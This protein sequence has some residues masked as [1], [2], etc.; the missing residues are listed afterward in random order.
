[1]TNNLLIILFSLVFIPKAFGASTHFRLS[2]EK[3]CYVKQ[4]KDKQFS[5][6]NPNDFYNLRI[7]ARPHKKDERYSVFKYDNKIFL[8]LTYCLI[9]TNLEDE[10]D[11]LLDSEPVEN[12][13]SLNRVA[14]K[15][16]I[17]NS[18]RFNENK[19][20]IELD[21][22][23]P[24]ITD[25]SAVFPYQKLNGQ[26]FGDGALL[27]SD[28]DKSK[29]KTS[30]GLLI[31]GGYALN[32]GH[33]FTFRIKIFNGSKTEIVPTSIGGGP[34]VD[35]PF[36]YTDRFTSVTIGQKFIFWPQYYLKPI[37]AF[38]LG[39]NSM[40]MDQKIG[41][42]KPIEYE[43]T[44]FTASGEIGLEF[45]F[46][47]NIGIG[48]SFGYEYLGKRTMKVK[49]QDESSDSVEGFKTLM[50]YSNTYLSMGLKVYFR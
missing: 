32:E 44:G 2:K 33:F 47:E 35:L 50:S 7:F 14:S 19:Y 49:G 48:T 43:S 30:T 37:L 5:E 8:T 45:V 25:D 40:T 21:A 42:E 11:D 34:V 23:M 15:S 6:K 10:F 1:M 26:D 4:Y 36:K 22:F 29:Y 24:S 12:N 17:S 16:V 13:Y 41:D 28:P 20:F 38:N 39:V 31:G 18:L 9:P 27:L 46:N 3:K